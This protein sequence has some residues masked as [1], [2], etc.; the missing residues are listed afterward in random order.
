MNHSKFITDIDS[1]LSSTD[2]QHQS[3]VFT[4][5]CFDLLHTG[6]L[7]VIKEAR[8]Q[9]DILIVAVNGDASVK[10]LKGASRPI[11][12]LQTR[13]EKLSC[14]PEVDYIISFSEATPL[15]II[16]KI[17]PDVLVK[18]GDYKIEDVV[19]NNIVRKVVIVP[20]LEGFSTTQI[21]SSG[22]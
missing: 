4:N 15:S 7:H 5:G 21:I 14:L 1:F 10:Q 17:Q 12:P 13:M 6:H 11:E 8:K 19:G 18:G 2:R 16:E 20:L 9:G 3:I 22:L